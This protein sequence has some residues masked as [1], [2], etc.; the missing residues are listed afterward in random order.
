MPQYTPKCACKCMY[1]FVSN[2]HYYCPLLI[3]LEY[4]IKFYCKRICP[5]LKL[6]HICRQ[7]SRKEY[8]KLFLQPFILNM[9][10]TTIKTNLHISTKEHNCHILLSSYSRIAINNIINPAIIPSDTTQ[11]DWTG[12]KGGTQHPPLIRH[13]KIQ[14]NETYFKC[15]HTIKYLIHHMVLAVMKII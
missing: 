3:T 13:I 15:N 10:K 9:P 6:P 12:W 8:G 1:V 14:Y 2:I 5:M 11:T 4:V 7:A